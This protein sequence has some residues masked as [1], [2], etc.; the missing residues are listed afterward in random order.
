MIEPCVGRTRASRRGRRPLMA[1]RE[2][3]RTAA[4]ELVRIRDRVHPAL[5]A[6]IGYGDVINTDPSGCHRPRVTGT[7]GSVFLSG[8]AA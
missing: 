4:L 5:R 3:V 8:D 2:A 6:P 1:R 7:H